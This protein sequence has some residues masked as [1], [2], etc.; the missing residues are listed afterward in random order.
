MSPTPDS[1]RLS[2]RQAGSNYFAKEK[3]RLAEATYSAGL[4]TITD[5]AE[6][7]LLY[8]NRSAAHLKLGNFAAAAQDASSA[9]ALLASS[10]L[11][12]DRMTKERALLR[13][14]RAFDGMRA[15][16]KAK[17]AYLALVAHSPANSEA[18][19]ALRRVEARLAEMATGD[20]DWVDV[21]ERREQGERHLDVGNFFGPIHVAEL[22]ERGGGRG[23]VASRD[24][25]VGE[26][27]VV[28]KAF[29]TAAPPGSSSSQAPS[30]PE[31]ARMDVTPPKNDDEDA[32]VA[33]SVML[34]LVFN[35][36]SRLVQN[37][38][39]RDTVYLFHGGKKFPSTG[40]LPNATFGDEQ[41]LESPNVP[42]DVDPERVEQILWANVCVTPPSLFYFLYE[43]K[44][45]SERWLTADLA[46]RYALRRGM[47]NAPGTDSSSTDEPP[48]AF[49]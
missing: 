23:V 20:Y 17:A 37:P 12:A 11:P 22:P 44:D 33:Q 21:F 40:G 46:S 43:G 1:K 36:V 49:C 35:V 42:R 29:A 16:S 39:L 25:A 45:T 13:L 2:P 38:A 26:L 5:P 31:F 6:S 7:L 48:V 9:L 18:T 41:E 14:A 34:D 19:S 27:L 30:L 8:L 28:E 4:R 10:S 3:Y 24:I 15:F 32:K 47:A